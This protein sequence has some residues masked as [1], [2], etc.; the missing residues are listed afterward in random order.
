MAKQAYIQ[1]NKRFPYRFTNANLQW[2]QRAKCYWILNGCYWTCRHKVYVAMNEMCHNKT[3]WLWSRIRIWFARNK[4]IQRRIHWKNVRRQ[5]MFVVLQFDALIEID[6]DNQIYRHST[7]QKK[8]TARKKTCVMN[9]AFRTIWTGIYT[10]I[11]NGSKRSCQHMFNGGS[12]VR[13]THRFEFQFEFHQFETWGSKE[14]GHWSR[15]WNQM[16]CS[17]SRADIIKNQWMKL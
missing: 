7:Q 13:T 2:K 14:V 4:I 17:N 11:P 5:M 16:V 15:T 12:G 3:G 1:W 9:T 10:Y 8:K 6:N